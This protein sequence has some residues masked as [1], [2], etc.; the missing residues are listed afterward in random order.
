MVEREAGKLGVLGLG[1]S[2]GLFSRIQTYELWS[3]VAK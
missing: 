1:W 3:V 2:H